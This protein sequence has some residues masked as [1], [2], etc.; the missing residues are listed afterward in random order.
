PGSYR[1][2][3]PH[4]FCSHCNF[5]LSVWGMA[6]E[7]VAAGS[8]LRERKKLETRRLIRR[9]ALDL[10]RERGLEHL[11]VEAIAERAGISPRTFFNYFTH[12]EDALVT[13]A[14]SVTE[15]IR[16]LVIDRPAHETPLH[17]IR[18]TITEHDFFSLMNSD[19]DRML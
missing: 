4:Q 1:C 7:S 3:H 10:S 9:V 2:E 8:G 12:K 15:S 19:R 5:A 13:D 18:A 6:V 16:R 11:T 14:S 17:A